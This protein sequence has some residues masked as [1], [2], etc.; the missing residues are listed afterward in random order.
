MKEYTIEEL[1]QMLKQMQEIIP[2][3]TLKDLQAL[4]PV[5]KSSSPAE[6]ESIPTTPMSN[7]RGRKKSS[8]TKPTESESSSGADLNGEDTPFSDRPGSKPTF[9]VG[10]NKGVTDEAI[11]FATSFY[12]GE[13]SNF[14]HQFLDKWKKG[15]IRV[16]NEDGS[17]YPIPKKLAE[18]KASQLRTSL[19]KDELADFTSVLFE[20]G[21]NFKKYLSLFPGDAWKEYMSIARNG[22]VIIKSSR[23]ILTSVRIG[24]DT[25]TLKPPYSLIPVDRIYPGAGKDTKEYKIPPALALR[26][27]KWDNPS[28]AEYSPKYVNPD[29][30]GY[31]TFSGTDIASLLYSVKILQFTGVLSFGATN[32]LNTTGKR[33]L[34]STSQ[35]LEPLA[36]YDDPNFHDWRKN[37]VATYYLYLGGC[38][39]KG[40]KTPGATV[41]ALF[42]YLSKEIITTKGAYVVP[43]LG[44]IFK[45]DI[46]PETLNL[47]LN[48]IFNFLKRCRIDNWVSIRELYEKFTYKAYENGGLYYIFDSNSYRPLGITNIFTKE[49]IPPYEYR[50]KIDYPFFCGLFMTFA[51]LGVLEVAYKPGSDHTSFFGDIDYFKMT[52][53]A[54]LVFE[55]VT[56]YPFPPVEK[57]TLTLEPNSLI[58][59]DNSQCDIFKNYLL[60]VARPIGGPRYIVDQATFCETISTAEELHTTIEKFKNI[61]DEELPKNWQAFFEELEGKAKAVKPGAPKRYNIYTLDPSFR[62]LLQWLSTDPEIRKISL[63]VE[64]CYLLVESEQVNYFEKRLAEAG[65]FL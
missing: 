56:S 48:M 18:V 15:E 50:S 53:L 33:I 42:K 45:K 63:R 34:A 35:C 61:V 52:P 6:E 2:T 59:K 38:H 3:L 5:K 39:A 37:M 29:L 54:D 13:L 43:Q 12:K 21:D 64:G 30:E 32:S 22:S 58:I 27:L 20:S 60:T 8:D 11:C 17:E 31:Q 7:S 65:Y 19:T 40:L 49:V 23:D 9:V 41:K 51:A 10:S 62:D 55:R 25:S 44:K 36:K 24:A 1:K 14:G 16:V 26:L 57:Y 47:Y 4:Y 46:S 28:L